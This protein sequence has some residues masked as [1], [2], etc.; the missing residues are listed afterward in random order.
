MDNGKYEFW[1]VIIFAILLITIGLIFPC[2]ELVFA[3]I[4]IFIMIGFNK[5]MKG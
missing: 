5:Y 3:G 4:G 1:A 2:M